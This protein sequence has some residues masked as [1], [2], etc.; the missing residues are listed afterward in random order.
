MY[1]LISRVHDTINKSKP[2]TMK[3]TQKKPHKKAKKGTNLSLSPGLTAPNHP[4]GN[5][6]FILN[7]KYR[8]RSIRIAQLINLQACFFERFTRRTGLKRLAEFQMST[9]QSPGPCRRV[10][11]HPVSVSTRHMWGFRVHNAPAPWLPFRFPMRNFPL[12]RMNT[13]IPTLGFTLMICGEVGL[14]RCGRGRL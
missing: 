7:L 2:H 6:M 9:R 13:A 4:N 1:I 8:I 12:L 11:Q 3:D 14:C 5:I 10:Y